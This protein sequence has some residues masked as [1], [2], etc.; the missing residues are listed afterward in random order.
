MGLIEKA[1]EALEAAYKGSDP[2]GQAGPAPAGVFDLDF[3]ALARAGFY[4]PAERSSRLALELRAVKRNLLRRLGLRNAAGDPRMIRKAGRQRNLVLVTSTRPGEGKTFCAVNLAL[5]LACEEAMEITLVD[6]DTPR[7]KLRAH[8]GLAERPGFSDRLKDGALALD[9]L[10]VRARQAP[11]SI[12]TEGAPVA[13]A[14]DLIGSVEARSLF[15]ALSGRA[16]GGLVIIDA[17]PVLATAEAA[18]LARHA[19][20]VL[21]V[22]EADATPEAGVGAALDDVLE[23]NPNVSLVLNRCLIGPGGYYYGS[24]GD[25]DDGRARAVDTAAEPPAKQ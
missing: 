25:Y 5:S 9:S 21:F 22:V 14:A 12:L 23:A 3:P 13:R 2:A 1:G 4:A 10:L 15:A 17:P 18:A 11:L 24:Y 20:E 8:F 6:A 19:D 7:P 16:A